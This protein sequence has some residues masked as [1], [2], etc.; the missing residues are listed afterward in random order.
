MNL[1]QTPKKQVLH[2]GTVRVRAMFSL[3]SGWRR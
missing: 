3:C 1:L 2:P